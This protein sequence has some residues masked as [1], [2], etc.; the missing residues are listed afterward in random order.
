MKDPQPRP[1]RSRKRLAVGVLLALLVLSVLV[2][3][4]Y[5]GAVTLQAAH[6]VMNH[7][8]RVMLALM[9]SRS[10]EGERGGPAPVIFPQTSDGFQTSA[11]YFRDAF[12]NNYLRGL[13]LS[14]FWAPGLSSLADPTN[15]AAFGS[16]NNAWCITLDTV[17]SDP[18]WLP[19]MFTR[20]LCFTGTTLDTFVGLDKNAKPFGDQ[21]GVVVTK[22]GAARI[23]NKGATLGDFN[24]SGATNR[25]L[26]P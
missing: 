8:R 11:D 26:R 21:V 3:P 19:M 15:P 1:K 2:W 22:G 13:D 5:R 16:Q 25:F 12:T 14:V 10:D 20:N 17:D 6:E 23:L 24:P 9:G 7:G 4:A 18:L